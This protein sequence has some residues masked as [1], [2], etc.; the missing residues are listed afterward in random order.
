MVVSSEYSLL[1]GKFLV[2][3]V[4]RFSDTNLAS[5]I[6]LILTLTIHSLCRPHKLSAHSPKTAP[7]LH[8]DAS[9]KYS[10]STSDQPALVLG[11]SYSPPSGLII[12]FSDSENS[13]YEGPSEAK[14][15]VPSALWLHLSSTL[16]RAST[17]QLPKP[18]S[19]GI[20]PILGV[21][22]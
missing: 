22:D 7:L 14:V 6:Q 21:V 8:P 11:R 15:S 1:K 13:G 9:C 18:R 12:C 4:L 10:C 2:L 19:L 16:K 20:L 5:E 3:C 17:C